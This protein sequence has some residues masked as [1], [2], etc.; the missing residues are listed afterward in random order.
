LTQILGQPCEFQVQA[1]TKVAQPPQEQPATQKFP[2][3]DTYPRCGGGV[4]TYPF[5]KS[6]PN[7][8][9]VG[10]SVMFAHI[11]PVVK[12]IFDRCELAPDFCENSTEILPRGCVRLLSV[13][14]IDGPWLVVIGLLLP[15][16]LA[17]LLLSPAACFPLPASSNGYK[18][19]PAPYGLL[20]GASPTMEWWPPFRAQGNPPTQRVASNASRITSKARSG[21]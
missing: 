19:L 16:L 5:N 15:L 11:G 7:V 2:T 10:D 18:R 13:Y 21:M 12:Q 9:L 1:A 4:D 6:L 17:L 20:T 3:V 8:L 14:H